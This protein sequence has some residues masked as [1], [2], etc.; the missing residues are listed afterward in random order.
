M[1]IKDIRITL[2]AEDG[3]LVSLVT[4]VSVLSGTVRGEGDTQ[5]LI[6]I[7]NAAFGLA[8]ALA[9]MEKHRGQ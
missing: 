1:K 6:L 8:G 2:Y 4:D 5:S 3:G 9:E 7:N